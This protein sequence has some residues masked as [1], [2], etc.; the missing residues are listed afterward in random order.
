GRLNGKTLNCE[1]RQAA[2][3][4]GRMLEKA[5]DESLS[6]AALRRLVEEEITS[7]IDKASGARNGEAESVSLKTLAHRAASELKR[8]DVKKIPDK[9]RREIER[10]LDELF[11]LLERAGAGS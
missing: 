11:L 6:L 1:E 7:R 5:L 3:L 8:L 10:K 9:H 2:A 4:R